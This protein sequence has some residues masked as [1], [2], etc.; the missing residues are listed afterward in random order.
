MLVNLLPSLKILDKRCGYN[1]AL[2]EKK[3]SLNILKQIIP[4]INLAFNKKVTEI[5][6]Q[7]NLDLT[8]VQKHKTDFKVQNDKIKQDILKKNISILFEKINSGISRISNLLSLVERDLNQQKA[9]LDDEKCQD[10]RNR[11]LSTLLSL[12]RRKFFLVVN[13]FNSQQ[14]D[15]KTVFREKLER[16]LKI[17]KK[18]LKDQELKDLM[19]NPDKMN[20]FVQIHMYGQSRA[21]DNAVN[22]IDEKMEEIRNLEENMT[23]LF[24]MIVQLRKIVSKQNE[25][26]DSISATLENVEATVFKTKDEME[27]GKVYYSS[28]REVF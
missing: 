12:F 27:Q 19:Q 21:L 1:F 8:L 9:E 25:T 17:Y 2:Q 10:P 6:K 22:D 7:I 23:K 14:S 28:A 24:N 3:K 26:L 5:L 13:R 16:Q 11:I 18:D 15:V 20:R 4:E